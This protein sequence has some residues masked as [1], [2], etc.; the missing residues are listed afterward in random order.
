[1]TLLSYVSAYSITDPVIYEIHLLEQESSPDSMLLFK[2]A[3]APA[4]ISEHWDWARALRAAR[5]TLRA[6][7]YVVPNTA[8]ESMM[9]QLRDVIRTSKPSE[10]SLELRN[11]GI[12]ARRL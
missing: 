7:G 3:I 5:H 2:V 6:L 12:D 10:L 4:K 11:P 1:M 9:L 8:Y